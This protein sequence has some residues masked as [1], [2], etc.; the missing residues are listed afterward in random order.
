MEEFFGAAP[1]PQ[2]VVAP[3]PVDGDDDEES[4]SNMARISSLDNRAS[5]RRNYSR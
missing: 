4:I 3:L 2:R 5:C 1:G